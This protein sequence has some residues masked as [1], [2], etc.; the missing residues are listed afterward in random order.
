MGIIYMIKHRASGKAYIG[1][2]QS[3]LEKRL[4]AHMKAKSYIGGAL[5]KHGREAFSVKVLHANVPKQNLNRL[6][7]TEIAMRGTMAPKGF[8]LTP[9]GAGILR[10]NKRQIIMP[11]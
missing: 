8:N 6:E 2:T 4:K 10:L 1:Q 11:K 9:G 5:R 3:T 7:R